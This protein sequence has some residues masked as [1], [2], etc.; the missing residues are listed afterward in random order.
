MSTVKENINHLKNYDSSL[1]EQI[2]GLYPNDESIIDPRLIMQKLS[3]ADMAAVLDI[4]P[5]SR[6]KM[7]KFCYKCA[8]LLNAELHNVCTRFNDA[9]WAIMGTDWPILELYISME[10]PYSEADRIEISKV[11]HKFSEEGTL[12]S[13]ASVV[14]CICNSKHPDPMYPSSIAAVFSVGVLTD[15]GFER[16]KAEQIITGYLNE[17]IAVLFTPPEWDSADPKRIGII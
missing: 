2:V 9:T 11:S 16:A 8:K 3:L 7:T 6:Y 1:A 10:R 15:L 4:L 14:S 13:F 5:E 17:E 12:W